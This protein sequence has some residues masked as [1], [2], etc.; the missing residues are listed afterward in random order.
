[1]RLVKPAPTPAPDAV[2]HT[3]LREEPVE[4]ILTPAERAEAD[5]E[6][7]KVRSRMSFADLLGFGASGDGPVEY[8]TEE[9]DLPEWPMAGTTTLEP[10]TPPPTEWNDLRLGDV[11]TRP[12]TGTGEL[13]QRLWDATA[14]QQTVPS[15]GVL[16]TPIEVS[17]TYR[18]G[19]TFRWTVVIAGI[20]VV[21]LS[22]VALRLAGQ[23]P[24]EIA[25]QMAADLRVQSS[26]LSASLVGF[27]AT[28]RTVVDPA[29]TVGTLTQLTPE[30]SSLDAFARDLAAT[31]GA[32]L[33]QPSLFGPSA[34]I[35][36]L[37][38]PRQLLQQASERALTLERRLSDTVTYRV[39]IAQLFLSP[40]L[41]VTADE[42]ALADLGAEL[43]LMTA[44]S[45]RVLG[46][47]PDDPFF[48]SHTATGVET[49]EYLQE[50]QVDYLGT[51]REGDAVAAGTLR[52][53][54]HQTVAVYRSEAAAP[55]SALDEWSSSELT[56]LHEL[57]ERATGRLGT[58][59]SAA[60]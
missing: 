26:R 55:L 15:T 37:E 7:P 1:M 39:A 54:W 6:Q 22:L 56:H 46:Q 35:E 38:S 4:E 14:E 16:G 47:L 17:D 42:A 48:A 43:G 40:D 32:E 3:P 60:G 12:A 2:D 57:M 13:V 33:P 19:R 5:A 20:G 23:R 9:F 25:E 11:A 27:D 24:V 45:E 18:S 10:P 21:V 41:P 52:R 30:L 36:L 53:E 49:L 50:W 28:A 44:T 34:P 29:S 59:E 51:L 31:A 58:A 8:T